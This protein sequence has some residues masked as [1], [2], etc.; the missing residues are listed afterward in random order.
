MWLKAQILDTACI[1]L[2]L[3]SDCFMR[4]CDL[5]KFLSLSASVFSSVNGNNRIY[6]TGRVRESLY[7]KQL[8]YYLV[9]SKRHQLSGKTHV[10]T[11]PLNVE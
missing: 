4:L 2:G 3:S 8:E 5:S 7:A 6:L 9:H 10:I 1:C 11:R